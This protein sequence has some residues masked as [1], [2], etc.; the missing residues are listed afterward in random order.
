M[1]KKRI[2]IDLSHED[3]EEEISG[4]Q[5]LIGEDVLSTEELKA[6]QTKLT[7][8]LI[9]QKQRKKNA[10]DSVIINLESDLLLESNELSV[11]PNRKKDIDQ[12]LENEP[13]RSDNVRDNISKPKKLSMKWDWKAKWATFLIGCFVLFLSTESYTYRTELAWVGLGLIF[14]G[15]LVD[16]WGPI[17]QGLADG[18]NDRNSVQSYNNSALP[19]PKASSA[20]FLSPSD[21]ESFKQRDIWSTENRTTSSGVFHTWRVQDQHVKFRIVLGGRSFEE[22]VPVPDYYLGEKILRSKYPNATLISYAG[23]V[24][25]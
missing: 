19:S 21:S 15:G 18:Q 23:I 12:L 5:D 22:T 25:N 20:N 9:E 4:L 17:L 13:L 6:A 10:D 2:F 8:L 3:L 11:Q 7:K 24:R 14:L 16:V 1:V